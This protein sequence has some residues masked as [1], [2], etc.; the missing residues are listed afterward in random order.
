MSRPSVKDLTGKNTLSYSSLDSF[1]SCGEKYRLTKI[2]KVAQEQSWWLAGGSAF[3]TASEWWDLGDAHTLP[4][5]WATAWD[6]HRSELDL[7]KPIRAGGRATKDNPNKED[8]QWWAANGLIMLND[9]VTWRDT[10]G[11]SIYE[12]DGGPYIE[13]EFTLSFPNPSLATDKSPDLVLQGFI[14]RVFVTDDGELVICDLKTGS[15]EPA[16]T[17]Q[18]G[19]Y[20][21]GLRQRGGLNVDLGCYFMSRKG[22]VSGFK[23]LHHYTDDMLAWWLSMFED[24][25]RS[26][27]FL[28][29]VTSMCGTC[30]VAPSCYAVGGIAP[31]TLPFFTH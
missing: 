15:R 14:D 27:R 18:L 28:P 23:S 20:A 19:I 24:S 25:V 7:T 1:I 3:H 16:A 26:E 6:K 13:Y 4:E 8:G 9:Y 30:Q 21:A 5:I 29:N 2:H 22:T 31:Y 17:T 10:S 12:Q 11:W